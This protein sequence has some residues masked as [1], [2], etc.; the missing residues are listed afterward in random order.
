MAIGLAV[1]KFYGKVQVDPK[2]KGFF[3]ETDMK[4]QSIQMKNFLIMIFGG[5]WFLPE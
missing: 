2:L 1:D 4:V 5:Y 3:R